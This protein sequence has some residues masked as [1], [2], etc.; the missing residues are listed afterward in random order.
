MR[1]IYAKGNTVKGVMSNETGFRLN[2]LP[3]YEQVYWEL[4]YGG[5]KQL[6]VHIGIEAAIRYLWRLD[7]AN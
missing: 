3:D 1:I 5:Q 4:I 6:L 7:D 2:G